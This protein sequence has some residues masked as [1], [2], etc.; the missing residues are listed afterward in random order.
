MDTRHTVLIVDDE[1]DNRELIEHILSSKFNVIMAADGEEGVRIAR[2]SQPDLILLDI[3]MPKMDGIAV[4]ETLRNNEATRH[5]PI[6]M[7]TAATDLDAKVKSFMTGADD[8]LSKPFKPQELMARVVSKVRRIE[9]RQGKDESLACGNLV[10]NMRKLEAS[11]NG[12]PLTL[13]VLEFNLLKC[14]VQN[15][16]RVMSRDR[17]LEAVW[18]DS[19]VSDRTVDTHIVSLRKKL[20]GFDH[21]IST[22]Y[23]AGYVLKKASS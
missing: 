22:V 5:I 20:T 9:E 17:I 13:S 12:N 14:F 11:I 10:L 18:R 16:D 4:C 7:L 1:A 8:F 23:G 15:K 3:T 21:E 2:A 19:I 6:I